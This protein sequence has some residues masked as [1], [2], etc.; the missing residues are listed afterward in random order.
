VAVLG[1]QQQVTWSLADAVL[2]GNSAGGSGGALAF[3]VPL[4][5]TL[6]QQCSLEGNTAGLLGGALFSAAKEL[7]AGSSNREVSMPGAV[8]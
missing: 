4:R 7:C 5:G 6:C 3:T 8:L 1:A 2:Q